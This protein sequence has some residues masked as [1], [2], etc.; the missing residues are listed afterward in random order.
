MSRERARISGLDP[1]SETYVLFA[2]FAPYSWLLS[3]C[4]SLT[5]YYLLLTYRLVTYCLLLT[6]YCLLLTAYCLQ[7]RGR[8]RQDTERCALARLD[9]VVSSK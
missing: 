4:R 1:L 3:I 8:R 7:V 2:I 6:A 9:V 5:T